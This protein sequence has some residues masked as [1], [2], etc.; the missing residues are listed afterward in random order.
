MKD[1][2]TKK[3]PIRRRIGVLTTLLLV[4]AVLLCLTVTIQ[5]LSKGYVNLF[6]YS[7]FRVVTG[8]MEP[9][10]PVGSLLVCRQIGLDGV[11]VGDIICFRAQESA[12][13]GR[14]MT[15]RVIGVF[16]APDG[17]LFFETRGD[18]NLVADGFMVSQTNFVGKVIWHTGANNVL[19]SIVSFFSNKIGFL[20]CIVIPILLLGGLLM[21]ECVSNIR[22][23]LYKAMRELEKESAPKEPMPELEITEEERK[24]M[25]ER[26]RAE[27]IEELRQSAEQVKT[28]P[29]SAGS[30]AGAEAGS[31]KCI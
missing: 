6:G 24:E 28:E 20:A 27:L 23:E 21:Q 31:E 4:F 15:H 19:S 1:L 14:M 18:A 26:I 12:I 16:T 11:Q 5:V 2:K 7:L 30:A 25:Y 17:S 13:F 22:A 8:S 9:T 10:I 29:Q 3:D